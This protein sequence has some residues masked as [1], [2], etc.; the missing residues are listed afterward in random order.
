MITIP[1]KSAIA[2]EKISVHILQVKTAPAS[3][4]RAA[5]PD[6]FTK[7]FVSYGNSSKSI[8]SALAVRNTIDCAANQP[9]QPESTMLSGCTF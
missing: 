9:T 4:I 3:A 1:M 8:K 7:S 2:A 6:S 5:L